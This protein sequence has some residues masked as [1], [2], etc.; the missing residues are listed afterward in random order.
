MH[1]I[2][3]A[4]IPYRGRALAGDV[5]RALGR[6]RRS[7]LT[8]LGLH[9]IALV[10]GAVMVHTGNEFALHSRDEIV[11]RAHAS[12]PSAIALQQGNRVKAALLDFRGNLF[13]GAMPLTG[14]GLAVVTAIPIV[15]YRGWIGGIVSVDGDHVSRLANGQEAFYYLLTLILQSIPYSLAGGAGV[16][17][18]WAYFRP[19][20]CYRGNK[21]LGYP[22]E[23]V[24]DALRIYVVV[25]P[26]FLVASLWEFLGR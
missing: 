11:A 16:N 1:G 7:I 4:G 25:V 3:E 20:P 6:S 8:I 24:F 14:S 2:G 13:L 5:L 26:L 12:D 18:G 9:I 15:G 23:A 22:K 21:W 19:Q 17:I 10:V